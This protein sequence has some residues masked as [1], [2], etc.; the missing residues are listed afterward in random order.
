M[1]ATVA[2]PVV[3]LSANWIDCLSEP[4]PKSWLMSLNASQIRDCHMP[5]SSSLS[6]R[7]KACLSK[8]ESNSPMMP[9]NI[10]IG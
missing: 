3:A 8:S 2:E 10:S 9:Q 6:R 4:E 1:V 5:T 7:Y